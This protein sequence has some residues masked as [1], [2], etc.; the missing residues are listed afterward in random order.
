MNLENGGTDVFLKRERERG[1]TVLKK[2]AS[3]EED[4]MAGVRYL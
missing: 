4:G 3:G 2:G 1:G